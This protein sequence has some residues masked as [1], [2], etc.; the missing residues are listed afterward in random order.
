MA[1][2]AMKYAV[3][4]A[5]NEKL[6]PTKNVK[7]HNDCCCFRSYS[8]HDYTNG[9]RVSEASLPCLLIQVAPIQWLISCSEC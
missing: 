9:A 4:A 2:R 7:S 1:G 6:P 3:C 8:A 5:L